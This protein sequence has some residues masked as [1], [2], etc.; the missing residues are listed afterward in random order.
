MFDDFSSF[1]Y[2]QWK[3]VTG[4]SWGFDPVRKVSCVGCGPVQENFIGCS[5]ISIYDPAIPTTTT[6]RGPRTTKPRSTASSSSSS[7]HS[8]NHEASTTKQIASSTVPVTNDP[9]K[10][11]VCTPKLEFGTM[12]NL[13]NEITYYC[14]SMC[15]LRCD[16]IIAH[17]LKETNEN[18]ILSDKNYK[19]CTQTCPAIC[20]CN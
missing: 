11:V 17:V 6:T 10:K 5:D 9:N 8:H 13:I 1:L 16:A 15:E 20:S 4:N 18:L 2:R 19:A 7:S 3:Y 14:K 12:I